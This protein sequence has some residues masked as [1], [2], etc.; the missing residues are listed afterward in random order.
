MASPTVF[1]ADT[2][3]EQR[4]GLCPACRSVRVQIRSRVEVEYEV[5]AADVP[6]ELVVVDERLAEGG[7]EDADEATCPACGWRGHVSEL[8]S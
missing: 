3:P 2:S 6:T 1:P 7:W 8:A 4:H 5:E